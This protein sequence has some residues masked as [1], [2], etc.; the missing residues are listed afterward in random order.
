MG[1]ISSQERL[2]GQRGKICMITNYDEETDVS[3]CK[4]NVS[5]YNEVTHSIKFICFT[6][7]KNSFNFLHACCMQATHDV[8][9]VVAVVVVLQR[10]LK[11]VLGGC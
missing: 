5:M 4:K 9:G 8:Q 11:N 3:V 10:N 2:H 7:A 1:F 6:K